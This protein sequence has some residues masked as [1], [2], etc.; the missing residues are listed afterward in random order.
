LPDQAWPASVDNR[1]SASLNRRFQL[2]VKRV[3]DIVGAAAALAVCSPVMALIGVTVAVTSGLPILFRQERVGRGG[4]PFVMLKFRTMIN[5]GPTATPVACPV[6]AVGELAKDPCDQRITRVG[7]LLR[8][9]SLDELPQLVNVL[10]GQMSFVGPRPLL[11]EMLRPYPQL[12]AKRAQMRPGITGI[13]QVSARE[14][15]R[16]V[17]QMAEPDC[18]YIDSFSLWLDTKLLLHTVPAW[19]SCRGAV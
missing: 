17:L 14:Q 13:W 7:R 18:E 2:I 3:F 4:R 19:V 6:N 1:A 12:A 9:L 16:S 15:N 10:L 5:S 8:R 11:V